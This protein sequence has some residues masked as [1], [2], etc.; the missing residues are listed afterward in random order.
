[1]W[2]LTII[3][4]TDHTFVIKLLQ[5]ITGALNFIRAQHVVLWNA[6]M[7]LKRWQL[8]RQWFPAEGQT[9]Q[10]SRNMD[11]KYFNYTQTAKANAITLLLHICCT[12]LAVCNA[13]WENA[14]NYLQ[15]FCSPV[16][17]LASC[18]NLHSPR[19][20]CSSFRTHL[21]EHTASAATADA[22]DNDLL[23]SHHKVKTELQIPKQSK[24]TNE[25]VR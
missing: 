8:I 20:T 10:I 5:L 11:H 22:A 16:A 18:E 7:T 2:P 21:F 25:K 17:G 12:S 24:K 4:G 1:M 15:A 23:I 9:K 19:W 14:P 3:T 13:S 6:H